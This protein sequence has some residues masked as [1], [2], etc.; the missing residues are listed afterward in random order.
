M[1]SSSF[2]CIARLSWFWVCW[3]TIRSSSVTTGR[4]AI[5]MSSQVRENPARKPTT[6]QTSNA[7]SVVTTAQPEPVKR[8]IRL[9]MTA[10]RGCSSV[11][12]GLYWSSMPRSYPAVPVGIRTDG[13]L[14]AY[15]IM[16]ERT[17]GKEG[18]VPITRLNHAV[19]YVRDVERSVAFYS[20]VLGFRVLDV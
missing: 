2:S 3:T 8:A 14:V 17:T 10:K 12:G 20:E 11:A 15:A 7:A 1:I 19:L 4:P 9:A 16:L 18:T 6:T 13:E 5:M